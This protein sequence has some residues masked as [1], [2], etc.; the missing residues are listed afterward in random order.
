MTQGFL[1]IRWTA[2]EG[3]D[4][5]KFSSASDVWSYAI[6]CVEIIQDG[7]MPY[8]AL[9]SNPAIIALVTGGEVHPRPDGCSDVV[10][11][12][13]AKCWS[14]EPQDRPGF[15]ELAEFFRQATPGMLTHDP[16]G[17]VFLPSGSNNTYVDLLEDEDSTASNTAAFDADYAVSTLP[18]RTGRQGWWRASR[19][20][21]CAASVA[22]MPH[23]R[24][25]RRRRWWR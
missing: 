2:P 18:H 10:Y 15:P 23:G 7:L 12:M 5:N 16:A 4:D 1:P 17:G 21:A 3:L 13:L 19:D 22:H 8:P 9:R 11:T 20:F 6:T 25:R 24:R 14:F